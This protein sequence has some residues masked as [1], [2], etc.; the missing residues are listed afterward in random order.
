[1]SEWLCLKSNL[2]L[3]THEDD[4]VGTDTP[5]F[6]LMHTQFWKCVHVS[7][8]HEYETEI[9]GLELYNWCVDRPADR[10]ATVQLWRIIETFRLPVC[11]QHLTEVEL[12]VYVSSFDK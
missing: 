8:L 4:D 7:K 2:R 3:S 6:L 9:G 11:M 12:Q 5:V 1:M 10:Y